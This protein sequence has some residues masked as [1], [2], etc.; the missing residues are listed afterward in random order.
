MDRRCRPVTAGCF[1]II[2]LGTLV[3]RARVDRPRLLQSPTG[4]CLDVD[5]LRFP[6][7]RALPGTAGPVEAWT[8]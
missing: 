4:R 5:D 1:G 7:E 8:V 3:A 2:V 6:G